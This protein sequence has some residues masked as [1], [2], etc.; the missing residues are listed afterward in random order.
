MSATATLLIQLPHRVAFA[1][2]TPEAASPIAT[3]AAR[4]PVAVAMRNGHMCRS[5][6]VF[7]DVRSASAAAG[8]ALTW[9]T[10]VDKTRALNDRR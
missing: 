10:M 3:L 5:N 8:L 7:I 6:V 9:L 2:S 4:G 1:D